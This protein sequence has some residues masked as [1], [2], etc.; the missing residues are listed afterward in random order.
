MHTDLLHHLSRTIAER[1]PTGMAL[2]LAAISARTVGTT[3]DASL[4]AVLTDACTLCLAD[5][6]ARG[7]GEL[8]LPLDATTLLVLRI[9]A[10]QPL[11]LSLEQVIMSTQEAIC[12][13]L[14]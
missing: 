13:G 1:R 2:A 11:R 3:M 4:I 8:H 5:V 12:A 7:E 10:V 14:P 6:A 9:R